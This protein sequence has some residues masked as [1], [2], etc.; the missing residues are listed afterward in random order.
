MGLG[1][2]LILPRH[3]TEQKMEN[4]FSERTSLCGDG[5]REEARAPDSRSGVLPTHVC[6]ASLPRACPGKGD[7]ERSRVRDSYCWEQIQAPPV[8]VVL[9]LIVK[10]LSERGMSL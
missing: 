5:A 7:W 3:F 10:L 8:V 1:D 2:H 9:S 6:A 4:G